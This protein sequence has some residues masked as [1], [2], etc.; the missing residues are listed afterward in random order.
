MQS[1]INYLRFLFS[2]DAQRS[3]KSCIFKF[4]GLYGL[5]SHLNHLGIRP[6]HLTI[7]NFIVGLSA[8]Y[9]LFINQPV[10]IGLM[11]LYYLIDICDGYYAREF[12]FESKAGE[13]LDHGFDSVV[14][15]I[16]L[17]KTY[18]YLHLN[19]S[20]WILLITLLEI[21]FLLKTKLIHQKMPSRLF[22]LFYLVS[23]FNVGLL[24]QLVYQ[25]LHFFLFMFFLK[26]TDR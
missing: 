26:K 1:L 21:G 19:I 14:A 22:I 9:F 15:I 25:P 4:L 5:F 11:F 20:L 12:H 13:L 16:M 6:N 18:L 8:V 10:F 7:S 24:I 17:V 23:L 2:F 3:L